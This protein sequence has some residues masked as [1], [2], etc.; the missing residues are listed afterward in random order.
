MSLNR[1]K[2]KYVGLK[3]VER[4]PNTTGIYCFARRILGEGGFLYIGKAISIK[5]RVKNHISQPTFKDNIFV[6]Q[7]QKIGFVATG[8]EIEALILEANLIKKYQPKYN[9]AW[10]DG[11]SHNFVFITKEEFPRVFIGHQK[12]EGVILSGAKDLGRD[13]SASPQNDK[14]NII[15]PFIDS[16]ALKQTLRILRRIFPYRTCRI[17]PKKACLYKDLNLCPAPCESYSNPIAASLQQSGCGNLIAILQGK[18]NS[19]IKN[20]QK[21]MQRASKQQDFE[22]AKAFRDQIFAL[23]NV[24]SHSHILEKEKFSGALGSANL[25]AFQEMLGIKNKIKRIEGYDIS[26]IHGQ[27]ATGSMVVF[28]GGQANKNEYR[29][30]KIKITGKPNDTAM[31]KEVISRRL[32]HKEW[33]MPQVMLIDGGK[34]QLNAAIERFMIYDSEFMNKT[35]I[36]SLAKRNNELFIEGKNKPVFLKDLPQDISNL[37]LQIRDESHRF[38]ISYHKKLRSKSF[39]N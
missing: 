1:E 22:K 30:F 12:K 19:V 23:E 38:A 24:F 36:V 27:E 3:D 34:A 6:P 16:G 37:I 35:K 15:G 7:T 11:K 18:K 26:N 17:L 4:L 25:Q 13:S 10:R 33:P 14:L 8:S 21:E 5:N 28:E 20:L 32:K 31:L 39:L 29:K 2:F 9:T